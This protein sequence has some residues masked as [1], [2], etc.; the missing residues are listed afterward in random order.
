MHTDITIIGFALV[1]C[2]NPI[3]S[4]YNGT[5]FMSSDRKKSK[6]LWV[7][8]FYEDLIFFIASYYN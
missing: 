7:S 6:W 3:I 8:Y 5:Y 4:F 1:R 2:I